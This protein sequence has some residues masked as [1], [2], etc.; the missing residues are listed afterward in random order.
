METTT[1]IFM[2]VVIAL[3]FLFL[4]WKKRGQKPLPGPMGLPLFGYL[5]FMTRK[6][7]IKLKELAKIYG[8]VYRIQLGSYSVVVLCDFQ[9]IKDAFANDVFMGRPLDI[10]FEL[11]EDT[12]R[13]GAILGMP[14]KEQRRF[15]LHMFRDLGFGKTRMEEHI[16]VKG[17]HHPMSSQA[18]I[19]RV[20]QRAERSAGLESADRPTEQQ[21]NA[22]R[23]GE[24][25][26]S[27]K[28]RGREQRG[29]GGREEP[30][31]RPAQKGGWER[32]R[33]CRGTYLPK[34]IGRKCSNLQGKLATTAHLQ[35]RGQNGPRDNESTR[36][37]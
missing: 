9:S 33:Q 34:R 13:T 28:K 11:S 32:K 7:Y 31:A 17:G 19:T 3:A 23:R 4:L 36:A 6:P 20:E 24:P 37:K 35:E 30:E 26:R 16:K 1:L 5:P 27:G 14:W 2:T 15:S 25:G 22:N 29:K 8:P 12:L 18:R 10:P 21:S